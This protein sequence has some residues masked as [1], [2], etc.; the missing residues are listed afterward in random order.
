VP[1]GDVG[2][3]QWTALHI[4]AENARVDVLRYL[5]EQQVDMNSRD[6]DD[7]TPMHCAAFWGHTEIVR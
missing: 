5:I 1:G 2:G 4:A 3:G 6:H 7:E